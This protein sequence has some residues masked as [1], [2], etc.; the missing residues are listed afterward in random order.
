MSFDDNFPPEDRE[1]RFHA[2]AERLS[3]GRL[4]A[5]WVMADLRHRYRTGADRLSK[6]YSVPGLTYGEARIARNTVS[7]TYPG[8][9]FLEIEFDRTFANRA[10]VFMIW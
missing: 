9:E 5:E 6:Q 8:Y 2:M 4:L 3:P 10:K 1:M 7:A